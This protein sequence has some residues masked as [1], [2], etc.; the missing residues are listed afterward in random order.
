MTIKRCVLL[1]R[2]RR[3]VLFSLNLLTSLMSGLFL[4][5]FR[6]DI[7]CRE[8]QLANPCARAYRSSR[9]KRG[10]Y[11]N[12]NAPNVRPRLL[13]ALRQTQ[14]LEQQG[15]TVEAAAIVGNSQFPSSTFLRKYAQFKAGVNIWRASARG[16]PTTLGEG[17]E[18]ELADYVKDCARR[19]LHLMVSTIKMRAK[20]LLA[21]NGGSFHTKN[22]SGVV[23]LFGFLLFLRVSRSLFRVL[24]QVCLGMTG[25]V[26]SASATACRPSAHA[27]SALHA[28]KHKTLS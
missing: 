15:M 16:A 10:S 21:A 12:Y 18:R 3:R 14:E 8:Q 11:V 20:R 23:R 4:Q 26:G 17:Q 28:Q 25:G 5:V 13:E 24:S 1:T 27:P 2:L 7:L 6:A 9:G 22:Q 19:N